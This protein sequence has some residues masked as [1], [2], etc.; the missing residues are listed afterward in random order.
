[1]PGDS[2]PFD[3]LDV[4]DPAWLRANPL[5]LTR[6]HHTQRGLHFLFRHAEGLRNSKGRI[7]VDIDVRA[8][9]GFC[10][11]WPREKLEV[12]EGP[13]A[14]WPK[15]LLELAKGRDGGDRTN[16]SIHAREPVPRAPLALTNIITNAGQVLSQ[17]DP[18]N[19]KDFDEWIK[20]MM[21]CYAAGI[22][23]ETFVEWSIGDPDYAEDGDEIRYMWDRLNPRE[24]TA[25]TLFAALRRREPA[26]PPCVP[27]GRREMTHQDSDSINSIARSVG[28]SKADE[29]LLFWAACRYGEIRMELWVSDGMLEQLLVSA[30]WE[31][32]LRDEARVRRQIKNGL[33]IGSQAWLKQRE[34][35]QN[36][37]QSLETSGP[38]KPDAGSET[39]P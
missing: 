22:D 31:C 7:A 25:A 18:Q 32:G 38:T 19:Y 6:V 21:A 23:R 35:E 33:R 13:V 30:A 24:V 28:R 12:E 29:E 11:W 9:G 3:V 2:V 8:D 16:P 4:D 37:A 17:L 10:V 27:K 20:L 1:M 26:V 14:E 15:G 36:D 34:G 39:I 5:P